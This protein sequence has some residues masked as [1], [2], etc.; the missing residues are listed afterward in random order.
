MYYDVNEYAYEIS[1]QKVRWKLKGED[2]FLGMTKCTHE[3]L[4]QNWCYWKI[5]ETYSSKDYVKEFGKFVVYNS[6]SKL[7]DLVSQL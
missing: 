2:K 6:R 3:G 7:G 4:E 5:Q 1:N